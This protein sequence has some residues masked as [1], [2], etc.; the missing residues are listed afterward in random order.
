MFGAH[1]QQRLPLYAVF[2]VLSANGRR[3]AFS[4]MTALHGDI[5]RCPSIGFLEHIRL[6]AE[7]ALSY[8]WW[9]LLCANTCSHLDQGRC[10]VRPLTTVPWSDASGLD[11][12]RRLVCH[13]I[14][15]AWSGFSWFFWCYYVLAFQ[16]QCHLRHVGAP[17]CRGR[18]SNVMTQ[19]ARLAGLRS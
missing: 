2:S 5:F 13:V 6:F 14:A 11:R 1:V 10:Q 4:W 8:D 19:H 7:R 15:V 18:W 12:E 16:L 3:F 17:A 9:R